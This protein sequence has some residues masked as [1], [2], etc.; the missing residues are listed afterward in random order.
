[1]IARTVDAF[2]DHPATGEIVVVIH[3]DDHALMEKALGERLG[4]VRVVEGG[5]TRQ[6]STL[7]GL[8]A[9]TAEPSA[10]CAHP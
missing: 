10:D 4:R 2:L 3:A 6:K 5:R 7:L 1:M 8:R 9:V